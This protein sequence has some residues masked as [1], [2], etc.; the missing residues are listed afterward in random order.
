MPSS[1]GEQGSSLRH[2]R[3]DTRLF[4]PFSHPWGFPQFSLRG[5][6]PGGPGCR[7][8]RAVA[9]LQ[10]A[11]HGAISSDFPPSRM[12]T[13]IEFSIKRLVCPFNQAIG[14]STRVF[15]FNQAI[16][17]SIRAF[18]GAIGLSGRPRRAGQGHGGVPAPRVRGLRDRAWRARGVDTLPC[19]ALARAATGPGSGRWHMSQV[20]VTDVRLSSRWRDGG[21]VTRRDV[22]PSQVRVTEAALETGQQHDPGQRVCRVGCGPHRPDTEP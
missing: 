18:N 11:G 22:S 16:G 19:A 21:T 14:L 8:R 20:R 4:R 17:L 15:H 2:W 5:L 12:P 9:L 3:F 7:T 10:L 6:Q 1:S 13:S